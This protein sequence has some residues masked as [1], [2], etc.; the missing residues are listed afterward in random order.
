[1]NECQWNLRKDLFG[2]KKNFVPMNGKYLYHNSGAIVIFWNMQRNTE[3]QRVRKNSVSKHV[4]TGINQVKFYLINSNVDKHDKFAYD[5]NALLS[6]S[7]V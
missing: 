7:I 6:A 2:N 3:L 4:Y 1:M 5:P